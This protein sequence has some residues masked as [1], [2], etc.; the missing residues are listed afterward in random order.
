MMRPAV[1]T[2]APHDEWRRTLDADPMS[3]PEHAPEWV[4]ALT[5]VGP[6]R[7]A[8]RAYLFDDGRRFVLPMVRR[9]SPL[10]SGAFLH[11]YPPGWGIGGLVGADLDTDVVR[12][13]VADLRGIRAQ[14][15]GIR[16]D[17]LQWPTWAAALDHGLTTVARR[18]HVVDLTGGPEAVWRRM[19]K[20]ARRGVRQ[21]EAGGVKIHVDRSGALLEEYYG[22]YLLSVDRWAE[23]QHEP[24]ALAHARA[25]RRDPLRKLQA[26]ARHMGDRFVLT[27]ATV[28]GVPA[29][30]SIT[31]LGRTAHDTR[32]A[33]DLGVV[34]K[35][36]AGDLVQWSTLQLACELGCSAYHLGE[37]GQSAS[38][39]AFK[40]KF[41]ARP[42]DYAELR[43]ERLPWTRMDTSARTAV[44]RVLR[45]QDA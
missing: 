7:D 36:R 32:S 2:P 37:S 45:F 24:R 12:A 21:A 38:L 31:L 30:G 42:H 43:V 6:Y 3:L 10:P 18:A 1:L 23:R 35:S 8:S 28:H 5:A 33:M 41:G 20:S 16:P 25:R 40:E 17:P 13:V 9:V 44:K 34:G 27:L 14:R 29:V 4:T 15:I 19:S 26:M 11:S 22:L 39:A